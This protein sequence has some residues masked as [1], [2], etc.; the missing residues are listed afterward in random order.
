MPTPTMSTFLLWCLVAYAAGSV[1]FGL[2]LMKLAG[3]GDVRKSGSGN[4]GATNVLRTGGKALAIVTLLLDIAKG[5]VPVYLAR[6]HGLPPHLLSFIALSG[7][8]GHIF[9]PW[10]RFKGGKGVATALGVAIAYQPMMVVPSLGV[11]LLLVLVFRYISLGSVCAAL[12]LPLSAFGLFGPRFC[13][14]VMPEDARW[15]VLAWSVLAMLVI[16]A[17]STNI[18]RLLQGTENKLWGSSKETHVEEA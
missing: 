6:R 4:I 13:L 2:L 16:R 10:L 5:F 8:L 9:T 7:V 14:Q 3:K 15:P 11:F 17:H 12:V 18:Q 1:P